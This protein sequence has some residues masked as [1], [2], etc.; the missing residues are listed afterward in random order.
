[1]RPL[2]VTLSIIFDFLSLFC[3]RRNCS[4]AS[5]CRAI[6]HLV[7]DARR[8][9]RAFVSFIDR[10]RPAYCLPNTQPHYCALIHEGPMKCRPLLFLAAFLLANCSL[11]FAQ[12]QHAQPT[13]KILHN[14]DVLRMY[15]SGLKSGQIIAKIVTSPCNFDTFPPVLREL[16]MKGV[17][18]IV[19]VA[20]RMVPYGPP[21]AS[22]AVPLSELAPQTARIQ[23]PAGTVLE[24]E[25]ASPVSS[26]KVS[27]GDH[28]MFLVSR[29]VLVKGITVID[30]GAAARARVVKVRPAAAWGRGGLLGWV[31]ED[32][33]AVDG[34][35]VPIKLS[36]H[37]A[38]KNRSRAV[39]AAA[40]V[41]GAA[42]F[43]YT[44][45]VGLIWAL[46]KGDEAVLD[47]SRK[48]AALV[49]DNTEVAGLM[50]KKRKAIYYSID[51]L[52]TDEATKGTG[53]APAN[54]S[55]RATPIGR[56]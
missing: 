20:M 13:T 26:A 22:T 38:G 46:K 50:P 51:K 15:K 55:F 53:L 27:E 6:T 12:T 9:I 29:R 52:K 24:I 17:P 43:P 33:V 36:D 8:G 14:G 31:M 19:I 32:V 41:T 2:L 44:P 25:I 54:D 42:V 23:I 47:E 5:T 37:L 21:S 40:I 16:R 10:P 34:T 28:I 48:S 7:A 4:P 56:H 11:L 1:M 39:V 30:R 35:R 49:S 45:P 3:G 18:D